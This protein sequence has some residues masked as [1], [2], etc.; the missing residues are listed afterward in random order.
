MKTAIIIA[1]N[2]RTFMMPTRED[3]NIRICDLFVE[4]ILN[5]NNLDIFVYTDTNDFYHNGVQYYSNNNKIEILNNDSF[6]IYNKI[7]F[8]ENNK[9]KDIIEK[10]L[11]LLFGNNLKRF[12]LSRHLM[13]KMILIF[14]N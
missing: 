13:L 4:N 3:S 5:N 7:D 10:E 6:R 12:L 8:I 11:L 1:G 2:L 14:I 9:A